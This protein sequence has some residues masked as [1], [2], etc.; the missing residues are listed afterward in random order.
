MGKLR[1]DIFHKQTSDFHFAWIVDFP[2]FL[3][4]DD[5]T[6]ESAHHPFTQPNEEDSHLLDSEPFKVEVV[7]FYT[8]LLSLV[9]LLRLGNGIGKFNYRKM[10]MKLNVFND[11]NNNNSLLSRI[12]S[13]Y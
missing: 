9:S 11:D 12:T 10:K 7:T 5:G 4:G 2:L 8:Q 13:V 3:E 1:F 6:P